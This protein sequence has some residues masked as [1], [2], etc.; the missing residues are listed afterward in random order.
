MS[1]AQG[2]LLPPLLS[3]LLAVNRTVTEPYLD[4]VFHV[5]QAQQYC[6]GN[7]RVWD[8]K[9]TTPPGLYVLSYAVSQAAV[10]RDKLGFTLELPLP[11][12]DIFA[13]RCINAVGLLLL[14]AVL[15]HT[16]KARNAAAYSFNP[17][18][19][20]HS[21]LNMVLFPP[22]FFFSALYYTDIWSTLFVV[23]FHIQLVK[24]TKEGASAVGRFTKL[25]IL[26]LASLGFRQTNIFWVAIFPAGVVFVQ[27]IDN[28]HEAV[29]DSIHRGVEGFGDTLYSVAKTSWKMEVVYDPTVKEAWLSAYIKA[30]VSLAACSLKTVSQPKRLCSLLQA[31][32]PFLT[33]IALFAVFI[34]WNGSVVL[35]DK[36]NHVATLHLPQMLYI[37]PFMAF[38]SLPLLYPYLLLLP[39]MILAQLPGYGTLDS[40]RVFKCRLIL[41]R[42][43]LILI[44]LAIACITVWA[45]T[46][47]HPFT[48]ADNRHYVFYVFRHLLRPWWLRYAVTPIYLLC[49]WACMQILGAGPPATR[50]MT[51]TLPDGEHSATVSFMLI[52]LATSAL[53][54]ITAPLVEPRYFILPWLFWRMHLPVQLPP[55]KDI[56]E[57][58]ARAGSLSWTALWED[59]DHRLW[60]ETAW[61]LVINAATGYIFLNWGFEWPL[62]P[63]KV[64]RFMW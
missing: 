49:A 26:G 17:M 10:L 36:S 19:F 29:R 55:S 37:S 63:G 45:N 57:K 20:Q 28:G 42:I 15:A 13:L 24:S 1:I 40:M 48:L 56:Q 54:L 44:P 8:P 27:H 61:L 12:C 30:S 16:Y 23:L 11:G 38:F 31:L 9:I 33:L 59:Y 62:E 25:L 6:N 35:G 47:V 2:A 5:R 32:A 21:A 22:I 3:W 51:G 46:I 14:V 7:F 41:P 58:K 4:E 39:I 53:Q 60:L 50:R 43:W 52:W 18:L 34:F 64:Q